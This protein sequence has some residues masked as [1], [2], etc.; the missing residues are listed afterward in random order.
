MRCLTKNEKNFLKGYALW[1]LFTVLPVILYVPRYID[2]YRRGTEGLFQWTEL[3]FRPLAD[4]L[5][6]AINLGSP[7][8]AL[9][10]LGQL[11]CIPIA[12]LGAL[13][14]TKAFKVR[15]NIL[16][17]LATLP[18]LANPYYLENLSYGFDCISMTAATALTA[19]AASLTIHRP[20]WPRWATI[21]TILI[22]SLMLY[23]PAVGAY[24]PIA[25]SG[26]TWLQ[27]GPK[28]ESEEMTPS[29]LTIAQA[30][31]PLISGLAIYQI[32]VSLLWTKRTGYGIEYGATSAPAN[33][34]WGISDRLKDYLNSLW[35]YWHGTALAPAFL[36]LAIAFIATLTT[37]HAKS[38]SLSSITMTTF[39]TLMISLTMVII[40]PGPLYALRFDFSEVPR[41]NAY[42]GGLLCAFTLPVASNA[43]GLASYQPTRITATAILAL[44]AWC[45]IVFSYAYGHAMQAQREFEASRLTGL[46]QGIARIDPDQQAQFIH[47]EGSM[48]ASPVLS[49]TARKFPL[50]MT[51]VPRMING[52]W[53][54]GAKQLSWH[55]LHLKPVRKKPA[56]PELISKARSCTNSQF[57]ICTAAHNII[58]EGKHIAVVMK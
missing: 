26:W 10:P 2:D 36:L 1:G 9:A 15:N 35:S 8:T 53:I 58:L 28:E 16:A 14:L 55:G 22:G 13:A 41:M 23:Q 17:I 5:Y 31:G 43:S 46:T 50:V 34:I 32:L 45:Q 52:P 7:A 47:F 37:R 57:A 30:L 54:W 48:P 29:R 27:L 39:L 25:I 6:Y 44:W 19:I 12:A 24:L 51:L 11:L 4:A 21:T 40:A 33:L 18:L 49:N 38:Q 56:S 42:L 20:S 3:G